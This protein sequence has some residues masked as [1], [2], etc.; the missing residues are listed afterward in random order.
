MDACAKV[1]RGNGGTDMAGK[2]NPGAYAA[3]RVSH[4]GVL[5]DKGTLGEGKRAV[6]YAWHDGCNAYHIA[7]RY[8]YDRTRHGYTS[9]LPWD[10]NGR[11]YA[12][13]AANTLHVAR[14]GQQHGTYATLTRTDP[15]SAR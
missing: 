14:I 9:H 11:R 1:S 15:N 3:R 8:A 12:T 4:R 2:G 5:G 13:R 7:P 6:G 10:L